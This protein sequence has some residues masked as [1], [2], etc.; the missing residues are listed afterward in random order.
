MIN[1]NTFYKAM[2]T[3]RKEREKQIKKFGIQNHFTYEWL[4]IL[5]EEI[6]EMSKEILNNNQEN[7][8]KELI[9]V[10]AVSVAM[11]EHIYRDNPSLYNP[12]EEVIKENGC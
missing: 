5:M 7:Y 3:I 12:K 1:D 4:A 2:A 9:Q 8:L 6:G 10:S 11:L